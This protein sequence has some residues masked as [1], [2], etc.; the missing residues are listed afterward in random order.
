M[1]NY[2]FQ[3][4]LIEVFKLISRTNKYIDE[5]TPWV[6][7]KDEANRDRLA[8]VLYNLLECVRICGI[9][10]CP[11]MP[12]T[13]PKI[14]QQIGAP[15]E[16][17][18]Y[19]AAGQWGL[20]PA[21]VQVHKGEVLFPRID[22]AKELEELENARQ[23]AIKAAEAAAPKAEPAP[24]PEGVATLITIEDFAKVEFKVAKILACEPV[25]RAKKLLRLEL[26]DGSGTPR[27]VVSGIHTWYE[28]EDLIGKKLV[29]VA[30]LKP[31][32]L[33][34]V[35]S[36]GMILAADAGEND[37]KVLFVDDSIPC[38]AKVR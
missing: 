17:T 38:G 28:P 2:A 34:G 4:A 35:E 6:L 27:Q 5:T 20:L 33:C 26:D 13:S 8:T 32:V 19:E 29:L 23:A 22:V 36:N 9:L 11:F 14:F 30:N 31:A 37:V 1:Q 3:N 24:A 12:A 16:S 10:L 25:K 21:Q 15:A 18:T 7:A